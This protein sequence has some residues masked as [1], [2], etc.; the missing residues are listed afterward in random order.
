M[1][2]TAGRRTAS[3]YS[4]GRLRA[5]GIDPRNDSKAGSLIR[6]AGASANEIASRANEEVRAPEATGPT[7]GAGPIEAPDPTAPEATG[8]S[9]NATP[10]ASGIG[11]LA[12][13]GGGY[14]AS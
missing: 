4:N 9:T 10:N 1:L 8:A 7:D 3:W 6:S 2:T 5:A 14:C 13:S 12:A 11:R